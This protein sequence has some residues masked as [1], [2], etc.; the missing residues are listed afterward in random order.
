MKVAS[1][2]LKNVKK[3]KKCSKTKNS[4]RFPKYFRK[5]SSTFAPSFEIKSSGGELLFI[6]TTA[7]QMKACFRNL[8]TPS[9]AMLIY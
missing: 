4:D 2:K 6:K 9:L 5:N 3:E 8:P 7:R 1:A